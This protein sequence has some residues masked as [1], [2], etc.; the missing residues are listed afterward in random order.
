MLC[1]GCAGVQGAGREW[2]K[3]VFAGERVGGIVW[4]VLDKGW[5]KWCKCGECFFKSLC[6]AQGLHRMFT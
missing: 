4:K 1:L 6:P 3:E 2:R 5:P